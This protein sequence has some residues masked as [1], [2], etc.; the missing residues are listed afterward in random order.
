ME[1]IKGVSKA[2][3]NGNIQPTVFVFPPRTANS[4]GPMVLNH[5]VLAFAGYEAVDG[6]IL[7]D[8][9][10]VQLTKEIINLGWVPPERRSRWDLLPIVTMAEGDLPVIAELPLD[11][12][13]LVEIRHPRY[14]TEFERLDLKWVAFPA[15]TRLGFDVGGVQ[16][17]AAP[18]IGW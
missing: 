12:C 18:F 3:N 15:L 4:T 8:P 11:L 7:G 10:S 1:L 6:S 9:A 2:F 13:K 17:T 5:Q 16:Y 14:N